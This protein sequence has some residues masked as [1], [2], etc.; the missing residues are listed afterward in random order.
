MSQPR[1]DDRIPAVL[2]D[3]RAH[4]AALEQWAQSWEATT[5]E[6]G[7]AMGQAAY[8]RRW[9]AALVAETPRPDPE[10]GQ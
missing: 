3:M 9:I 5:S 8:I 7:T 6:A 1:T 2:A 10:T 4:V